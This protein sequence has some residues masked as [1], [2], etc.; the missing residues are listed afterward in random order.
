MLIEGLVARLIANAAVLAIVGDAIQPEPA[1]EDL[2]LYPLITYKVASDVTTYN[3]QGEDGLV[4]SRVIFTCHGVRYGDARLLALAVKPVLSN[5]AGTLSDGT[6]IDG[7]EIA[8]IS[9]G[10][11]DGSRV[12][13]TAVHAMCRYYY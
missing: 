7:I 5:F 3:M 1:P 13:R 8:N 2:S 6:V 9:D 10:F 11:D 12:Y 4:T